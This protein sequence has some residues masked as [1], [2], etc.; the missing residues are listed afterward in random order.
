MVQ[1]QN[2]SKTPVYHNIKQIRRTGSAAPKQNTAQGSSR[3]GVDILSSR[4][5]LTARTPSPHRQSKAAC[6]FIKTASPI[7]NPPAAACSQFKF[8]PTGHKKHN[9]AVTNSAQKCVA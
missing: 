1:N 8:R 3:L 2:D 6:C 9:P 4:Q 5:P 7:S